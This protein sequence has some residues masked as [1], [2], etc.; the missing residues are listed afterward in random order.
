LPAAAVIGTGSLRRRAQ[1]LHRRADFV[2]QDIRGNVDTRLQKL[3]AGQ[4]DALVL[5]HAGLK[6]LGLAGQITEILPFESMLPA[7]GQGALAIEARR[8]DSATRAVLEPLD[9]PPTHQAVLAERMLL[10]TLLGGCLAPVGGLA[11]LQADGRLHLQAVVLS[12]D[13]KVR[14]EASGIADAARALELGRDVADQLIA[15]GAS[16]WIRK[17]RQAG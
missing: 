16:E 7:V 1:L 3:A 8:D 6:R 11:R 15:Q 4:F 17:S 13:G 12:P 9:H 2:M 14:I 10:A 5:A